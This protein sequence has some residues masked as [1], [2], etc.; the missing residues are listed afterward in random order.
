MCLTQRI[1]FELVDGNV[2]GGVLLLV[3]EQ[4]V[5]DKRHLVVDL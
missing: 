2:V 3:V 4:Q 5:D 1:A